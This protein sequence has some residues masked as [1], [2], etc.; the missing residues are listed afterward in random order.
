MLSIIVPAL[1]EAAAIEA[2]LQAV[3]AWRGDGLE[4][5]VV[6][7]GSSD[8]T[9]PLARAL[10]DH[11]I[12]APR[13]R[14]QQMNAGAALASGS[15]LWFLHADTIVPKSALGAI[16]HAIPGGESLPPTVSG[17]GA[18]ENMAWGRFDVT[19]AGRAAMLRVVAWMMNLRSRATGIATGDQAMFMTRAAFAAVGGF[20]V[21]PL[22]EDIEMS[23]RLG[24]LVAPLCLRERVVTS[25]RRWEERGVWRTIFLMWRLRFA[26]FRGAR[27]A[28]LAR[29]Y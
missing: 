1:N 12:T 24:R 17:Q 22:M 29:R 11:V 5:I 2:T 13:G 20:P 15:L 23:R 14:A 6:D 21:Q 7:G 3:Q 26:Y 25:G 28:D 27:A 4:V 16:L 18:F 8:A 19:I 9:M 10:A